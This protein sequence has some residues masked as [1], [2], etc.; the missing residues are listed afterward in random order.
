MSINTNLGITINIE[1]ILDLEFT[2]SNAHLVL[3][4]EVANNNKVVVYYIEYN[5]LSENDKNVFNGYVEF[6]GTPTTVFFKDGVEV[7]DARI[8]GDTNED[9]IESVF[10]DNGYIK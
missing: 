4:T 5:M 9:R 3:P 7:V 10:R 1:S 6:L 2:T 8:D